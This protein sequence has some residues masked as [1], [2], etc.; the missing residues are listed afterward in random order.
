VSRLG[1]YLKQLRKE[2]GKEELSVMASKLG[3]Q[4]EALDAIEKAEKNPFPLFFQDLSAYKDIDAEVT[5]IAYCLYQQDKL[6][7]LYAE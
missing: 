7:G 2:S 1:S 3:I 4:A 5:G 6:R